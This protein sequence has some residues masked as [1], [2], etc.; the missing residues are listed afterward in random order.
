[1]VQLDHRQQPDKRVFARDGKALRMS[2]TYFT[3][4]VADAGGNV[5]YR[6]SLRNPARAV[7]GAGT[8]T[9]VQ[10][11]SNVF[12]TYKP[13][14][15]TVEFVPSF[16]KSTLAVGSLIIAPDYEDNDTSSQVTTYQDIASYNEKKMLDPRK[17]FSV[18][19]K[20]PKLDSGSIPGMTSTSPAVINNGFLDFNAPP[21][22]G[23]VYL[24]AGGFPANS[25]VGDVVLTMDMLVKYKR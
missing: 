3:Q 9:D 13:Q 14:Y 15:L 6:F 24:V 4:L 5:S 8:Y 19:F 18:R 12:D 22:D 1:M 11:I 2:F 10:S 7:N 25:R 16:A 23:V 21:Y 20:V 17:K